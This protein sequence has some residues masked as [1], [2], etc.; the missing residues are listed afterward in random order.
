MVED[1]GKKSQNSPPGFERISQLNEHESKRRRDDDDDD[2][3]LISLHKSQFW[4][5]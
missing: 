3:S 4:L 1:P 5:R 2:N